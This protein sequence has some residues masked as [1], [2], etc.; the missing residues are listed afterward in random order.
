MAG[1]IIYSLERTGPFVRQVEAMQEKAPGTVTFFRVSPDA[2]A[3]KFMANLSKPLEP[4]F[5]GSIETLQDTPGTPLRHCERGGVSLSARGRGAGRCDVLVRGR[6]GHRDF[7]AFH[8]GWDAMKILDRYIAKSFLIGYAIAFCVLIG[9]WIIIDLFVNL[10]EFVEQS[11]LGIWTV[12]LHIATFYGLHATVYFRD[13]AGVITVVAAVFSLGKMVRDNELVAMHGLG[14]QRPEDCR[15]HRGHGHLV[16]GS[17][18][19]GSGAVDPRRSAAN[20]R[21]A[22]GTSPAKS[23]SR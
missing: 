4:Q 18:G 16:H 12:S 3:V 22:M 17:M 21:G 8:P 19:G 10:D 23:I 5:A 15:A 1:P 2:E 14:R 11:D 6:I 13:L 20:S 9:L 7:V